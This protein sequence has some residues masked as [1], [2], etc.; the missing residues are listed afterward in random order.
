M[1]G[2]IQ[3][4]LHPIYVYFNAIRVPLKVVVLGGNVVEVGLLQT[5]MKK[6]Q[7]W[8]RDKAAIIFQPDYDH[9]PDTYRNERDIRAYHSIMDDPIPTL[10]VLTSLSRLEG[11]AVGQWAGAFGYTSRRPWANLLAHELG[12]FLSLPHQSGTFMAQGTEGNFGQITLEQV[13]AMRRE[14]RLYGR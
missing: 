5:E 8:Y 7:R 4:L 3:R 12:H 13:E 2:I 9:R 14:A 10:Y 1:W 11:D 6:V